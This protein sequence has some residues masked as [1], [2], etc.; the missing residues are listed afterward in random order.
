VFKVRREMDNEIAKITNEYHFSMTLQEIRK[1]FTDED[2][3]LLPEVNAITVNFSRKTSNE[4]KDYLFNLREIYLILFIR[5]LRLLLSH[6]TFVKDFSAKFPETSN[7]IVD[8]CRLR[9][10]LVLSTIH[11]MSWCTIISH[12][13]QFTLDNKKYILY[14][15]HFCSLVS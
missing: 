6:E 15:R 4:Q 14:T 12:I 13:K 9:S 7:Y 3:D 2:M 8:V 10:P 1:L 5:R 11:P